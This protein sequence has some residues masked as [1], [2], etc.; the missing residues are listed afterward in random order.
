MSWRR[1]RHQELALVALLG[2]AGCNG[3]PPSTPIDAGPLDAAPRDTGPLD[4]GPPDTGPPM[5]PIAAWP[6]TATTR[7]DAVLV[8]LSARRA[9]VASCGG[10]SIGPSSPVADDPALR[11]AARCHAFD[12]L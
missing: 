10:T 9:M 2:V 7:E 12:T 8:E 4:S 5:C 6:S 1:P 3:T 11:R